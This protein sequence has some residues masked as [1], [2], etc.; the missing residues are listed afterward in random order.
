MAAVSQ[1]VS[2]N[3]PL[4]LV[5]Y[6]HSLMITEEGH[7]KEPMRWCMHVNIQ[8]ALNVESPA[9]Y[10]S[11]PLGVTQPWLVLGTV[12]HNQD[13]LNFHSSGFGR[14]NGDGTARICRV[15]GPCRVSRTETDYS[16]CTL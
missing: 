8:M 16:Q 15:N 14:L 6:N 5:C 7:N 4:L 1:K 12:R 13:I 2:Q 9:E 3:N 11:P 10:K